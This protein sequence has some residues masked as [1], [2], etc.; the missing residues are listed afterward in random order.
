MTQGDINFLGGMG[1]QQQLQDQAI[2]DS[3]RKTDTQR[4]YAP[5]EMAGFMTDVYKGAPSTSMTTAQKSSGDSASPLQNLVGTV[6]GTATAAAAAGRS[7]LFD[8]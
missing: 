2:L 8:S 6:A 3:A 7:G 1:Q 4:L 5:F